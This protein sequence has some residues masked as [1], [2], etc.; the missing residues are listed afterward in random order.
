M[1][2]LTTRLS[3]RKPAGTD[4]VNVTT[5][6]SNNADIIDAGTA[7]LAATNT[8]TTRQAITPAIDSGDTGV[9]SLQRAS[10]AHAQFLTLAVGVAYN[11]QIGRSASS[12]DFKFGYN[13]GGGFVEDIRFT[14]GGPFL[15]KANASIGPGALG[16]ASPFTKIGDSGGG[17][18]MIEAGHGT[19]ANVNLHFRPKG[20]GVIN[21]EP[22]GGGVIASIDSGAGGGTFTAI[23]VNANGIGLAR[24]QFGGAGTG[25]GG[26]GRAL[27]I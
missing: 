14:P 11:Y 1:A 19:L 16:A 6:I 10:T 23:S 26:V 22:G 12:D 13:G 17:A 18:A 24:V 21:F 5:D 9:L 27:Y 8:F 7:V 4:L 3:L 20:S 15:F 2:T 25:P